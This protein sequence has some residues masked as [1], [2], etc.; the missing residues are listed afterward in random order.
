MPK[1]KLTPEQQAI[2]DS[3]KDKMTDEKTSLE[4]IEKAVDYEAIAN[5]PVDYQIAGNKITFIF[6][7]KASAKAVH[8]RIDKVLFELKRLVNT[9][10]E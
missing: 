4:R 10:K 8:R 7:D 6:E 3:V 9:Y 5:V 1:E 2:Y